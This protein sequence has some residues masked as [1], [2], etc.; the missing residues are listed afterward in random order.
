[1]LCCSLL[2]CPYLTELLET[3]SKAKREQKLKLP[4]VGAWKSAL[5]SVGFLF[6]RL[7][8]FYCFTFKFSNSSPL[9]FHS[10]LEPM[11]WVF[12]FPSSEISNQFFF[13][14]SI[15]LPETF[16]SFAEVFYIFHFKYVHKC[17]RC[18]YNCLLKQFYDGC[19]KILVRE[20]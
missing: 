13:I 19:F 12:V 18:V 2:C 20:F 5:F 9:A 1:M 8:I 7:C 17:F 14:F 10:V 16:S 3:D 4:D 15:S 11:Q 6:F